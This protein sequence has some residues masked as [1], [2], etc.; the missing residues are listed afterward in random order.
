MKII[1]TLER[2]KNQTVTLTT[3]VQESEA[4]KPTVQQVM[5]DLEKS[6]AVWVDTLSAGNAWI[7]HGPSNGRSRKSERPLF[8]EI[9]RASDGRVVLQDMDGK[10]YIG[11]EL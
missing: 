6:D 5:R 11:K 2:Y 8:E 10:L 3:I 9:G 1:E 7:Y 4:S